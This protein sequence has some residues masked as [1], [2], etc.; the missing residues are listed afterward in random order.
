MAMI[1]HLVARLGRLAWG[2][3]W[4]QPIPFLIKSILFLIF[5]ILLI[6]IWLLL[7][8]LLPLAF[9]LL[10]LRSRRMLRKMA[11]DTDSISASYRVKDEEPAQEPKGYIENPHRD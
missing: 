7:F 9:L 3:I 6:P 11:E 10:L 1:F 5:M 2:L 4:E 8:L